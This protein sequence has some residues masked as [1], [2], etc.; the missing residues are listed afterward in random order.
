[1]NG[2]HQRLAAEPF[3]VALTGRG[4]VA[5]LQRIDVRPLARY[6]VE[7]GDTLQTLAQRYYGEQWA[8]MAAILRE[9]N[10]LASD[11]DLPVGLVITIPDLGWRLR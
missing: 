5:V 4:T 1:M 3:R 9:V 7:A 2:R 6:R 10:L 11:T 8:G